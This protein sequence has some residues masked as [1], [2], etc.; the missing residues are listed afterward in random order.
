MALSSEVLLRPLADKGLP[1][2]AFWFLSPRAELLPELQ[3]MGPAEANFL[4][5]RFLMNGHR[6]PPQGEEDMEVVQLQ[7]AGSWVHTDGCFPMSRDVSENNS[8]DTDSP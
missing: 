8:A 5:P 1:A 7:S 2:K 6:K 3:L 4:C